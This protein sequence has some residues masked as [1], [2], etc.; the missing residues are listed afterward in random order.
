MKQILKHL[1][2]GNSFVHRT[3]IVTRVKG[4]AVHAHGLLVFDAEELK[5]PLVQTTHELIYTCPS[6]ASFFLIGRAGV[7]QRSVVY[8]SL[9]VAAFSAQRAQMFRLVFP[10]GLQALLTKAVATREQNGLL[11]YV[12]TH[13]TS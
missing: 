12:F 10:A 2:E 1:A 7:L 9:A 4:H 11:K 8:W 5:G 6:P 3:E 13:R